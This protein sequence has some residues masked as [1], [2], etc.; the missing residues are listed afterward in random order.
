MSPAAEKYM[1]PP[2]RTLSAQADLSAAA[3][4]HPVCDDPGV[5]R[6]AAATPSVAARGARASTP[7]LRSPQGDLD[8]P[9]PFC[10]PH[11]VGSEYE[12]IQRAIATSELSGDGAITKHCHRILEQTLGVPKAL[13]TTSCT[14]ALE[15]AALLLNLKPGDEIIFPSFT[16]VSTANAFVLHGG[17]PVFADV[18]PD[19]LNLD[20]RQLERLITPR[21]RAIVPVHYAGVG[22]EMDAI[23]EVA[24]RHGLT[25]IEDNAH[26]LFAKYKGRFL[27]TMGTF[28]AQSFHETKNFTC[29]EGGALLINDTRFVE[30]AEILRE[31][32]TDRSRFYR[33]QVDKYCWR[34][35]GSSYLPSGILAAF[36]QGQLEAREDIQA[37]RRAIFEFYARELGDWA[38][39][40]GVSLPTIPE[41]CEQAYHMFYML[42]PSATDRTELL[43]H[44]K[45]QNVQ[46]TFHYVPLHDSPMGQSFGYRR[47]DCPVTE[48]ISERLIRLPFFY[49]LTASQLERVADAVRA[50]E[51][52]G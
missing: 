1:A 47:G 41:H 44:L 50:F 20:E 26:G 22:C 19:T 5:A 3:D 32:G 11:N 42:M 18:R 21:T 39:A 52:S 35:I 28:G 30:R 2:S 24:R 40:R 27:G 36:L 43:A 34:D 12:L 48:D 46:A 4:T 31:K 49:D 13:L 38:Q 37:R 7:P 25:V 33:G 16:F 9:I 17:K 15:M 51:V 8:S 23:Q 29:G 14:H 6:T 45:R 10:R